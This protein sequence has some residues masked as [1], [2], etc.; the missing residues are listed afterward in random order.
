[1]VQNKPE[2]QTPGAF[3]RMSFSLVQSSKKDAALA[4]YRATYPQFSTGL[5]QEYLFEASCSSAEKPENL[6]CHE[7][8]G[9]A[10][11]ARRIV[12]CTLG[13]LGD[14][15]PFLALAQA[16]QAEG[17][18]RCCQSNANSSL[19]GEPLALGAAG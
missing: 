2:W 8:A 19:V 11:A 15:H 7:L 12:L 1:M 13:S 4:K 3:A 16:L 6:R 18:K 17:F 14:L 5:T 9:R 10:A